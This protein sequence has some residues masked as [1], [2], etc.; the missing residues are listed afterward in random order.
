MREGESCSMGG[1]GGVIDR[2]VGDEFI[3]VYI[4]LELFWA[5]ACHVHT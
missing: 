5:I 4:E 3:P 1:L 2:P